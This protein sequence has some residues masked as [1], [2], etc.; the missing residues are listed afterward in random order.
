[1]NR[2]IRVLE[3]M[4]SNEKKKIFT[5]LR[6]ISDNADLSRQVHYINEIPVQSTMRKCGVTV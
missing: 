1:M 6:Y 2:V 4:A 3:N 5:A